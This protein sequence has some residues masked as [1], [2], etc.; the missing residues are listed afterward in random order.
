MEYEYVKMKKIGPGT[1]MD[2]IFKSQEY[3]KRLF[4]KV[5]YNNKKYIIQ[6]NLITKQK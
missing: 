1:K 5:V 3:F 6:M 4:Y 2:S